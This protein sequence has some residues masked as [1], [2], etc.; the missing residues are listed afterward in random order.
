MITKQLEHL[1]EQQK[2]VR[3]Q[4]VECNSQIEALLRDKENLLA[5]L[6]AY[7]GAIQTCEYLINQ[8]TLS[9]LEVNN[10]TGNSIETDI[11]TSE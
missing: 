8:N 2:Q 10:V 5:S 7:A 11:N 9:D 4:F 3:L 1:K 6:N